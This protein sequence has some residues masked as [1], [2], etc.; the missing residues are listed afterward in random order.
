MVNLKRFRTLYMYVFIA[1]I[2]SSFFWAPLASEKHVRCHLPQGVMVSTTKENCKSQIGLVISTASVETMAKRLSKGME[3]YKQGDFSTA[4]RILKPLAIENQPEAAYTLGEIYNYAQGVPQDYHEAY[5]WHLIAGRFGYPRS[6]MVLA[7]LVAGGLGVTQNY[8][9]SIEWFQCAFDNPRSSWKDKT[10][11]R[12]YIRIAVSRNIQVK[13]HLRNTVVTS[14]SPAA[15][16]NT[17]PQQPSQPAPQPKTSTLTPKNDPR[18][19]FTSTVNERMT[20]SELHTLIGHKFSAWAMDTGNT[21]VVVLL[22]NGKVIGN[23][24]GRPQV[25][26]EGTWEIVDDTVCLRWNRWRKGRRYCVYY[27]RRDNGEFASFFADTG[28]VSSIF[29]QIDISST[30]TAQLVSGETTSPVDIIAPIIDISSVIKVKTDSPII[31]GRASDN[32]KVAHVTVEGVAVNLKA[33]GSFSFSR[34]VPIGGTSVRIKAVDEWGNTSERTV[35]IFRAV[36]EATDQPTFASLDP[37]TINGHSNQNAV[38]LI[39]G[40]S[41][42]SRAPA[43]TFADND[44]NVFSD[45]ARRALGVARSNMKVLTNEAASLVD[46]KVSV[47][48]WLRGRIEDGRTDVYVFFAGHG[49]ASSNGEELYLLPRDGEP[50]LLQETALLRTELFDVISTAKPKSATFFLDT[51]YSGLSRGKETLLANARP[52]LIRAKQQSVPS[53]FT[54]FS[55]ASDQQISSGLDEAKHGLFSYYLMKGMEGGADANKDRKITAGELHA[56]LG[57]NVKKQ[58][59]RLGREQMPELSGNRERVLVQ[60]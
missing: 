14:N 2:A 30:S 47:K 40:V 22:K 12:M 59:I 11:A 31:N 8:R 25:R 26:D 15:F 56:Y 21:V 55:A 29:R 48:Q 54:V 52:I 23:V 42:Y 10:S 37:T 20:N 49:L 17:S 28:R 33:G 4:L 19:V 32:T 60:W 3:A 50:S 16:H 38:A 39:I 57:K 5:K 34:Y 45:F 6:Q 35:K 36:S 9:R 24:Q 7:N 43:A 44:A 53:G 1:Y 41:D 58:A 46:L 51:C 18:P 27:K 13:C